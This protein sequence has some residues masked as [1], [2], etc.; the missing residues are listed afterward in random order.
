MAMCP[1]TQR[2]PTE[3]TMR[4]KSPKSYTTSR[5]AMQAAA[6]VLRQHLPLIP[7]LRTSADNAIA[8][9]WEQVQAGRDYL[10]IEWSRS[11][12]VGC[13]LSIA[14]RHARVEQEE[15]RIVHH[16]R[17]TVEVGWSSTGRGPAEAMAAVALYQQVAQLACL[18]ETVLARLEIAE[19]QDR[20]PVEPIDAAAKATK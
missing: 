3:T 16:L 13:S 10:N 17:A 11:F 15:T 19:V 7:G 5:E 18:V 1:T 2:T 9:L 8:D 4:A 14:L 20:P 6:E 12:G